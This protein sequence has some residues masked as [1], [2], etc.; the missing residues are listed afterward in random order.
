VAD[1]RSVPT[2]FNGG[3][4]GASGRPT[5]A[6]SLFSAAGCGYLAK[7]REGGGKFLLSLRGVGPPRTQGASFHEAN[8]GDEG[9]ENAWVLPGAGAIAQGKVKGMRV[10]AYQVLRFFD[11][12]RSQ[13]AGDRRADVGNCFEDCG[14][15]RTSSLAC[16]PLRRVAFPGNQAGCPHC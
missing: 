10:P 7:P 14:Q 1:R 12:D 9:V 6:L 4:V 5:R 3:R 16:G 8:G 11:P 2:K 13:I 15:P